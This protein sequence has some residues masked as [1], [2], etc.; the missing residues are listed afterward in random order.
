MQQRRTALAGSLAALLTMVALGAGCGSSAPEPIVL[1]PMTFVLQN[2]TTRTIY[3]DNTTAQ[4]WF[5]VRDNAGKTVTLSR[6]CVCVCGDDDCEACTEDAPLPSVRALAPGESARFTWDAQFW[7]FR[8]DGDT[9]ECAV[10]QRA[11]TDRSFV[12]EVCWGA[13]QIVGAND[14]TVID[15]QGCATLDLKPGTVVKHSVKD[16]DLKPVFRAPTFGISN[17]S[18]API[19]L[20]TT[21]GKDWVTLRDRNGVTLLL[22]RPECTCSCDEPETCADNCGG[23]VIPSVKEIADGADEKVVW[24]GRYW[25]AQEI[26]EG[27]CVSEHRAG[28]TDAGF[29]AEVCWGTGKDEPNP[30]AATIT[31][32]SC[33]TV[34]ITQDEET[35]HTVPAP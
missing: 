5:T 10:G 23:N 6:G 35:L 14:T 15:G 3:V 4:S 34:Q 22:E 31:G 32:E 28:A 2:D 8:D 27:R 7:T 25:L 16:A 9:G 18:G 24:D 13:G 1:G 29:T 17:A 12:S 11:R 33:A 21:H 20:N 19:Y 30:P 26:A